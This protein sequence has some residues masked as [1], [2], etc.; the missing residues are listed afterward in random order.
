MIYL[1][2]SE[3]DIQ[4]LQKA[5]QISKTLI[6]S[7]EDE[8]DTLRGQFKLLEGMIPKEKLQAFERQNPFPLLKRRNQMAKHTINSKS[9]SLIN[10][11]FKDT[12]K[13]EGCMTDLCGIE[14]NLIYENVDIE[15]IKVP[16]FS[17]ACQTS[18]SNQA[19]SQ[20]QT[21]MILDDIK[22]LENK[23]NENEHDKQETN[24]KTDEYLNQIQELTRQIKLKDIEIEKL[25]NITLT[26]DE[27]SLIEYSD[28]EIKNKTFITESKKGKD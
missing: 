13:V 22:N 14:R 23:I 20:V 2:S 25:K 21:E 6:E 24:D 18:I 17:A 27:D 8:V 16:T 9:I 11:M 3:R 5:N 19:N 10:K 4:F 26:D 7:L 12:Y 15:G 28:S 1:Y